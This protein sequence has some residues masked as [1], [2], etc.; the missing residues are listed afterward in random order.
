LDP[1]TR[2]AESVEW[3][4]ANPPADASTDFTADDTALAAAT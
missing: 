1:E 4:L 2:V 3:H